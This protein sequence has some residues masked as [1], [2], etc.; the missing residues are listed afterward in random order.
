M[1]LFAESARRLIPGDRPRCRGRGSWGEVKT[2]NAR[3]AGGAVPYFCIPFG[4]S[5]QIIG[6]CAEE[7]VK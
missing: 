7:L 1:S 3:C 6:E 5:E 4:L 2:R